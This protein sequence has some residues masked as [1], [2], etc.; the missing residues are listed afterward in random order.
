MMLCTRKLTSFATLV[1]D[2]ISRPVRRERN[3]TR[4][5]ACTYPKITRR[6][7]LYETEGLGSDVSVYALV[8]LSS[9]RS[10]CRPHL[11]GREYVGGD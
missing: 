9:F 5:H 6:R 11:R 7:S 3:F 8:H 2:G 10:T 4:T 1:T